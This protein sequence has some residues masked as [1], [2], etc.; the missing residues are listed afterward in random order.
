MLKEG[1]APLDSTPLVSIIIPAHNEEK[2]LPRLL[3][4][5]ISQTYPHLQIIL[6]DDGSTDETL[7][8]A[9][10]YAEKD[11]RI[12]VLT[13]PCGGVSSA[14]NEGLPLCRGKY[15]RFADSDDTLP[16]DSVAL[17]VARAEA[18][19]A[20]LVISAYTEYIGEHPRFMNLV[21]RTDTLSSHEALDIIDRRSNSYFY[22]VLWNKLFVREKIGDLRFDEHLT[23]GEDFSFVMSYLKN[24]ETIAYMTDSVYD[25]RRTPTSATFRQALDSVL[26]PIKNIRIKL[27]LYRVLKDLYVTRGEY[28]AHRRTL[29]IYIFRFGMD[30]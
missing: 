5:V 15:I 1:V 12:T 25:Y 19:G 17:L 28:A 22:G 20:D 7:T 2:A 11:N 16:P 3:D 27:L 30:M 26:H 6:V 13:R 14:R 21:N 10:R 24:A 4:S 8:V 23:W 29:W 18:D 9:R